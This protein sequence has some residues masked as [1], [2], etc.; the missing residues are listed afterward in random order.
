MVGRFE[1]V[2]EI[3]R[4]GFGVV[5]EAKDRELGRAVA[6]KAVLGGRP[7]AHEERLLRE[8][9]AAARLSHPNIVTLFDVGRTDDGPYLVLEL[10][11]GETLAKRLDQGP[12]PIHEALRIAVEVAQGL[13]HAHGE[14]VIHRDLTPG[15][16]F[17]CK[18]GQVKILD[19]GMAHAFGR[20]K[21]EGGTPAYMAP[22][23]WRGAPEDERTD[24]FA[25]AVILYEMLAGS[26]PFADERALTSSRPAPVLEVPGEP[27][28]GGLLARMLSKAAVNRPRDGGEVLSALSTFQRELERAPGS[29]PVRRRRRWR[30]PALMAAGALLGA[31]AAAI[32]IHQKA[33]HQSSAVA[34]ASIAVLPFADM[35]PQRDQGYLADGVAEEIL[36]AL[37][38]VEGLKVIG[39]TSSFSFKGKSDDLRSIGQKLGVA[40]LLEG[41]VRREGGRVRINA[42]VVNA[43]DGHRVWSQSYD[44]QLTSV[45]T[46]QEDIAAAVVDALKVKLVRPRQPAR[47][48]ERTVDADAYAE[49]L[50]GR[51]FHA[52]S[53][54]DAFR[55]AEQAYERALVLDP[56]VAPAWAMLA[57]MRGVLADFARSPEEVATRQLGALD[58]AER[59]VAL[60]PELA[61][62][63]AARGPLRAALGCYWQGAR[64]DLDHAMQLN[65][66]DAYA[67][68]LRAMFLLAP[69]SQMPEA[70]ADLRRATELDPL[71]PIAWSSLG[72]LYNATGQ[73]GLARDALRRSLEISPEHDYGTNGLAVAALLEGRAD[74]ALETSRRSG[75]ESWRLLVAALV[76]RELG[77]DLEA[78]QALEALTARF[79]SSSAYSIAAAHAWLGNA[80]QAFK[81]LDRAVAQHDAGLLCVGYDPLLRRIRSDPRYKALL[82]RMNLPAP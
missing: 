59:A 42:Q 33:R 50:R 71:R 26:R 15:N 68:Y 80:E 57:H 8:A 75:I 5:W 17:L 63:F 47:L 43:A 53:S 65:P 32:V 27:A 45:L 19:L 41:S 58:A 16:V 60:D 49:Y 79:A 66:G 35:S 25:L 23:Q 52:R 55:R 51:Q 13:A 4:G 28:L 70:I 39:G 11:R 34:V 69:T 48:A 61:D 72:E 21:L 44:R 31:G 62:G 24:V 74:T 54:E 77:R 22:E 29:G 67:H 82:K 20:R 1:L 78:R 36:Y 10:L 37:T 56:T 81:W 46:L 76:Q 64:S 9:E 73:H 40:A 6:F 2:K 18:D 38:R 14:G 7:D 3:G 12:I 30:L